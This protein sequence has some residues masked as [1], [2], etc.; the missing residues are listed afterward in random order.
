MSSLF[1]PKLSDSTFEPFKIV[2]PAPHQV[3]DK[4]QRESRRRPC[5]SRELH[6]KMKMDSC[7]HRKLWI[8]VFTGMTWFYFTH[9]VDT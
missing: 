4:L 6:N 7:L 8:P 9:W 1:L 2:I 3:R 5:E